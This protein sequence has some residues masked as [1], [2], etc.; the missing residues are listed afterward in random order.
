M[1]RWKM[2]RAGWRHHLPYPIF[3]DIFKLI[4]LNRQLNKSLC[5]SLDGLGSGF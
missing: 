2:G 4:S 5:V 3:L 1:G